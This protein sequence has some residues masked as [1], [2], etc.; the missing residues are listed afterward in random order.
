MFWDVKPFDLTQSANCFVR[1]LA[2]TL[3]SGIFTDKDGNETKRY[4]D[5]KELSKQID[6]L[7]P[8]LSESNLVIV[9]DGLQYAHLSYRFEPHTMID[10]CN[11][12]TELTPVSF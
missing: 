3:Q 1:A 2:E 10:V 12:L 8:L 6:S 4:K 9:I 7:G 5:L 11:W